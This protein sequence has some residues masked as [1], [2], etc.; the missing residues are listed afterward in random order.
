MNRHPGGSSM[1]LTRLADRLGRRFVGRL[2]LQIVRGPVS[3]FVLGIPLLEAALHRGEEV[4]VANSANRGPPAQSEAC[5]VPTP[6]ARP[7][8]SCAPESIPCPAP[9]FPLPAHRAKQEPRGA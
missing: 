4:P 3:P 7:R 9:K 5:L 1:T 6:V 8:H 2:A